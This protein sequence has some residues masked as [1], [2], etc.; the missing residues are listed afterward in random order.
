MCQL[1]FICLQELSGIEK[2]IY[3]LE[4]AYI[5]ESRELGNIFQGW[6]AYVSKEKFKAKGKLLNEERLFSLSSATSPAARREEQQVK[7]KEKSG[8]KEKVVKDGADKEGG[9]SSRKKKR[10]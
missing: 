8:A 6:D 7:N 9:A 3:E 5:D 1:L 2:Q 4:T 10:V